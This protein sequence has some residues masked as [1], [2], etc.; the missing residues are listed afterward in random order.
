[1]SQSVDRPTV[2]SVTCSQS[3]NL[4]GIVG[5][6][7][8]QEYLNCLTFRDELYKLSKI[9]IDY[10]KP[11]FIR[12]Q[13]RMIE[14]ERLITDDQIKK[15]CTKQ[16]RDKKFVNRS[17]DFT[18][19]NENWKILAGYYSNQWGSENI[20]K[21]GTA[22]PGAWLYIFVNCALIPRSFVLKAQN[23]IA[24]RNEKYAHLH[25]LRVGD[26][27]FKGI[28]YAITN[29]MKAVNDESLKRDI[30]SLVD[31]SIVLNMRVLNE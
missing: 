11:F 18:G 16:H 1:M 27:S 24:W 22:D 28:T 19:W 8:L 17:Y 9:N 4:Q 5:L 23:I 3:L 7:Q 26:E 6:S 20:S 29:W 10:L 15:F 31:R 30:E 2:I 14:N 12:L 13:Q 25:D 21:K